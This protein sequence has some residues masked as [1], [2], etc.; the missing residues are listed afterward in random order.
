MN[1]SHPRPA[2][3]RYSFGLSRALKAVSFPALNSCQQMAPWFLLARLIIPSLSHAQF[4]TS[5]W[6][7]S[8][9]LASAFL[10]LFHAVSTPHSRPLPPV[11]NFLPTPC[12]SPFSFT[13]TEESVLFYR[14]LAL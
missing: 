4:S 9:R 11:Q 10:R 13:Y 8:Q 7:A 6:P 5:H 14:G 1:T 3:E 2:S 12:V